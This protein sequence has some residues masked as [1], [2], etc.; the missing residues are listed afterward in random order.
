MHGIF[1]AV[2]EDDPLTSGGRV[3]A[4]KGIATIKGEDGKSRRMA[5]IGDTAWCATCKTAGEIIGGAPTSKRMRDLVN[6]GRLQAVGGDLVACKCKPSPR[7]IATYGLR[8][9]IRDIAEAA[10]KQANAAAETAQRHA[11]DEQFTLYDA[12]GNPM[13]E[14]FYTVVFPSGDRVHGVTD[15]SGRTERHGTSGAQNIR[16]YLGHRDAAQ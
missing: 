9:V 14:T 5:F 16:L 12:I 6:G 1:Y 7:I 11:Y 8:W 13:P 10:L 3:F 2:V 15:S 4:N